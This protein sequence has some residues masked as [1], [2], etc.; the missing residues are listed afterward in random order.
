[1]G[2]ELRLL[3]LFYSLHQLPNSMFKIST[4]IFLLA[5]S[6]PSWGQHSKAEDIYQQAKEQYENGD[7]KKAVSG[8]LKARSE[9]LKEKNYDRILTCTQ[10]VAIYYQD[11]GDGQAAEKILLETISAIPQATN[12]QLITRATLH[13][14]LGF[15]YSN[16]LGQPQKAI[17]SYNQS[18]RLYELAGKAN[19]PEWAFELVNRAT[20]YFGLNNFQAAVDDMLKAISV[21][22]KSDETKPEEL[23]GYHR[24]LGRMYSEMS[25]NDKAL[26][27]YET[28]ID[29]LGD[30]DKSE[31][32][33]TLLNDI[34]G[35]QMKMGNYKSALQNLQE[36]LDLTEELFGKEASNYAMALVNLGT[37]HKEMGDLQSAL[38]YFTEVTTIYEKAP[39][40]ESSD[41]IDL[42]LT[43]ADLTDE[44]GSTGIQEELFAQA[45]NVA[46]SVY[47]KNSLEEANVFMV[48]ANAAFHHDKFDESLNFNFKALDNMQDNN[49]PENAYYAQIYNNVGQA[50]DRLG[51]M[52][53]ALK[54]K[55][56]ARELYIKLKGANHASVAMAVGNIGLSYEANEE[57]NKAIEYL[58]QSVA[59]RLKIQE[60]DNEDLGMDYLNI[61][62]AYLKKNETKSGIEYLE[63]AR[64]IY[65]GYDK[66][67]Y[68]ATIYNRLAVGYF[69]LHDM[70]KAMA[71]NQKAIIA[72]DLNFN[73][74][75]F[76]SFPVQ[77]SVLDYYELII[78]F[79]SKADMYGKMGDEVSLLK[80]LKLL[81]AADNVL[82]EKAI[83]LSNA[84]DRLELSTINASFTESGMLL[85]DKLYR[86]TK[87]P[88]WLEKAFYFSERSKANE[89]FADIQTNRATNL[90]R[91]PKKITDR[92]EV[93]GKRFHSLQQQ[94]TAA[95]SSQNQ[96]LITK[97]KA[98]EFDL[99]KEM[100]SLQA[101]MEKASPKF[102]SVINQRA[103]PS[104]AEVK[105]HLDQK[106]ALVSYIITDSAKFILIGNASKLIMKPIPPKT[107]IEKWVRG[108]VNQIKFQ[109]PGFESIA[110][111]LTD[112]L[113]TPVESALAELGPIE[114]IIIMADGA[115]NYLPFE[116][117][118]K[119]Q[120][121]I[122]KYAIY[123]QLSGALIANEMPSQ[124]T[125][126]P[127][128]IALAPVFED[129]ETN[130]LN[131]SCER[132]VQ[133]SIKADTT[134]RAFSLSGEY[135]N[136][137]PET[138]T[139]VE[140]INQIYIDK[141]FFSK[142]FTKEAAHEALIKK[143]ELANY[144]FI[145]FATHGFV[146][147]QYPELSGLLLTQDS[148]STED[149]I[150]YT[151]EILGLTLKAELVTLS[152]CET[153]LGKKIE[154]EG[155]R[156][157]T[158]AFLFAGARSVISSLWK[159]ADES[160]SLLMIDFYNQ[161]HS[162]K[163]KVSALRAAKQSLLK[164]EKYNHPFYWAPFIQIGAK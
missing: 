162:G 128:F 87:N 99:S 75:D 31:L 43:I 9:F 161:L 39:P 81:E 69:I 15:T 142:S 41:V 19:T 114:K 68:K 120:Y 164:S 100:E 59:I 35:T 66:N 124:L 63:K 96:T 25:L 14:N 134:S 56:Q 12:E 57:Y 126:K 92:K 129:K 10:T 29:L 150:L 6:I 155:V 110:N 159:V 23:A 151:G 24:T 80:G 104:W 95:Y 112:I 38:H 130:F 147:S 133:L 88:I 97:L 37:V 8:L 139:E 157:L 16:S 3:S 33:T 123:Y 79:T 127:S 103:L 109:V 105:K 148:S 2:W 132:F 1:M 76:N 115:L 106:T 89:L 85:V 91:I 113:W 20:T 117:L 70:P 26:Q 45:H 27:R 158:T 46:V 154:G 122:E 143:G 49:Y 13:D 93:I 144:D 58:Q 90:S 4:Y 118:G 156:G 17:D 108:F 116:A 149:G 121:L 32:K 51:D 141:G 135:I 64:V 98:E 136:P 18:M 55:N 21:Y 52:A 36:A 22:E 7:T 84:R 86:V 111:R 50:Y 152:A 82:K 145:H 163:D 28:A 40:K 65:D 62:L 153:A 94:I 71:C 125:A 146:N 48:K 101:E 137:L 78:S 107:D 160:T 60:P 72:N 54:Y 30:D 34:G 42:L 44:L 119:G 47:G 138:E 67:I 77:P 53:L 140:T 73:S 61:G 102:K 5:C 83:A 11:K 131:K 74:S